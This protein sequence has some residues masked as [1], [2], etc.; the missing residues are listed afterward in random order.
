[1]HGNWK[2]AEDNWFIVGA[3]TCPTYPFGGI[4][5]ISG[6]ASQ[7]SSA[8]IFEPTD[9]ATPRHPWLVLRVHM[10]NQFLIYIYICFSQICLPNMGKPQPEFS[11]VDH[12]VPCKYKNKYQHNTYIIILYNI[13]CIYVY[14]YGKFEVSHGIP[15]DWTTPCQLEP[16]APWRAQ[17]V[18]WFQPQK[19][20][21]V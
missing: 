13:M 17:Q 16:C 4:S 12:H 8:H 10:Y 2:L 11:I 1:M 18:P 14:I 9:F 3:S 19:S 5:H 7:F 6:P 15:H 20:R 21:P